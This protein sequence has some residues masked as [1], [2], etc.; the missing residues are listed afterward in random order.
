METT[1]RYQDHYISLS[2]QYKLVFSS[3]RQ[4]FNC[5]IL[6]IEINFYRNHDYPSHRINIFLRVVVAQGYGLV[7]YN[8]VLYISEMSSISINSQRL[9]TLMKQPGIN[10]EL[11]S[12]CRDARKRCDDSFQEINLDVVL[13]EL[14]IERSILSDYFIVVWKKIQLL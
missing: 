13:E 12:S 5:I 11:D 10:S 2:L 14:N 4:G 6:H 9:I 7:Q 3:P 8:F 1:K